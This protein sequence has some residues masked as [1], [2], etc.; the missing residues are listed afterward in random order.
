MKFSKENSFVSLTKDKKQNNLHK[1]FIS[2]NEL[3]IFRRT[4]RLVNRFHQ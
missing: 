3:Y 4:D 2:Y 1:F